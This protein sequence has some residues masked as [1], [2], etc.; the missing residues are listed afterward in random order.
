[1]KQTLHYLL[2]CFVILLFANEG[3]SQTYNFRIYTDD[4]GLAQSYVYSITQSNKGSL[5]IGTGEGFCQ[6]DGSKFKTYTTNDSLAENFISTHYEDS[7][8]ITWIGHYQNGIS[9]EKKGVFYKLKSS[10]KIGSRITSF[11]EDSHKNIWVSTQGSGVYKIDTAFNCTNV[12]NSEAT[13]ANT[14]LVDMDNNILLATNYGLYLYKEIAN[15]IK[16][17]C[18]VVGFEN[19]MVKNI[20]PMDQVGNSFW[21]SVVGEGIYGVRKSDNC[22]YTFVKINKE[23]ELSNFMFTSLCVDNQNNLWVGTNGEGLRKIHFQNYTDK[24]YFEVTKITEVNGLKNQYILSIFEDNENNIWFGTLGGGLLELPVEKFSFFSENSGLEQKAVNSFLID[25][26][27]NLWIGSDQGF[28]FLNKSNDSLNIFFDQRTGFVN[29]KVNAIVKDYSGLFWI[30]TE[31]NGLYSF[32]PLKKIFIPFSKNHAFETKT[33]NSIAVDKFG[34]IVIATTDGVYF[35]V[36]STDK[37]THLTTM[38]GLLHNNVLNVFIDDKG[39]I[40]FSSNASPPYYMDRDKFTVFNEIP[41]L[42]SFNINGVTQDNSGMIWICTDGDGVVQYDGKNFTNYKT[43]KGLLSNYCNFIICD[44]AGNIWIGHRNGFSVKKAENTTFTTITKSDGLLLTGFNQNAVG[45]DFAGNLWFGGNEGLI[46]YNF[47]IDK[48]QKNEPITNIVSITINKDLYSPESI[49]NLPFA[50]YSVRIDFISIS[51]TDPNKVIYK[52]RLLGQDTIWRTTQQKFVDF[53]K[54]DDGEYT[55]EVIGCNA[56]GIWNKQSAKFEFS[57]ASPFWKKVWF[58]IL[59]FAFIVL[60]T[61]SIIKRRTNTLTKAKQILEEKVTEKTLQLK[62]EKDIV[63]KIKTQLEIKNRDNIDSLIYAKRI[64]ESILPSTKLISECFPQSF[65][66][67]LPRDIVSGDFYWFAE[68]SEYYIVAV[69]DCTGHGVPGAFMS[70]VGSTLLNE[71]VLNK[72]ITDPAEILTQ[73]NKSVIKVLKQEN[74][75]GSSNDGMDMSLCR[76]NKDLKH[77]VYAGALRPLYLFR[78]KILTEIKGNP[79]SIGG[80]AENITNVFV[81]QELTLEKDDLIYIFSDGFCDQFGHETNK[82]FS[83]KR[84]KEM[85][86]ANSDQSMMD[87]NEN[88]VSALW[89]W[90]GDVDQIDDILIIAIRV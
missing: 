66:F 47:N 18:P 40:W 48:Q 74:K 39:R 16:L 7:R 57:I 1:M 55:F 58:Y 14:L 8:G 63:E 46:R 31:N 29:D 33:I 26:Q 50:N 86:L 85:I 32:D 45:K 62:T 53:P 15:K 44:N 75:I 52:Y 6:F 35:Y 60:V 42:R 9:Y 87:Q 68:T 59:L 37:I 12:A 73:L 51:F 22:Y 81:D 71:I 43:D 11:C 54:L 72:K 84:F 41:G 61:Y 89:N 80:Y 88:L 30:G 34:T 5:Q 21:I 49:I 67:F 13:N 10:E 27:D 24:N 83:T 23:L 82:K 69:V 76:F 25:D 70:L 38:E 79:H 17:I 64:Q 4:N 19:K 20:I 2:I 78:N 65:L 77:L 3:V 36:P 90:K 28:S 56:D